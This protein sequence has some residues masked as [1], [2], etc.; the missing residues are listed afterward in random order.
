MKKLVR[1]LLAGVMLALSLGF[2]AC[3][4]NEPATELSALG[5]D[6]IKFA[7]SDEGQAVVVANKAIDVKTSST[8][9]Y[10][11]AKD[12]VSGELEINGSTSVEAVIKALIEEYKKYQPDAVVTYEGTGSGTGRTEAEKG[13]ADVIGVVSAD[14]SAEQD[15]KLD[16]ID[17]AKDAIA[18]VVNTASDVTDLTKEQVAEIFKN[19]TDKKWS[20]YGSANTNAVKLYCRK[21]GSG[22][23]SAFEELLGIE[24]QVSTKGTTE[25]DSTSALVAGVAGDPDGIGYASLSEMGTTVKSLSIGGVACNEENVKNGTYGIARPF[26]FVVRQGMKTA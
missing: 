26:A 4:N 11:T 2:A 25:Q 8:A 15:E 19:G 7:L 17:F 5:K 12:T 13:S 9:A 3:G 6:F 20:D 14:L 24:D 10:D 16:Q 18:V 22:T 1:V 23:R 21:T